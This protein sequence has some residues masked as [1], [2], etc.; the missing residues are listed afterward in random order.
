[1]TAATAYSLLLLVAILYLDPV[2]IVRSICPR[3]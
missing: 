2:A 3:L 1:M